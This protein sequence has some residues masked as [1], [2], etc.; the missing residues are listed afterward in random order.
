MI[1]FSGIQVLVGVDATKL[2]EHKILS[3]ESF[4]IV[5]FNF[6]HVGG[7]MRIE[8]NRALLRQFFISVKSILQKDGKVLMSLCDGQG[9]T[10]ADISR[11]QWNDS[12]QVTEMAAHGSFVLRAI[13]PFDS[14]LFKTYTVTGY[15]SLEKKF[16]TA[17]SLTHVFKLADRPDIANIA[18]KT[19]INLQ[20][21]NDKPIEWKNIIFEASID[22][23]VTDVSCNLS[24]YSKSYT[25][26]MTV[27]ID[28]EFTNAKFYESLYNNAGLIINN[29]EL[30]GCYKFPDSKETRTFRITYKSDRFPLYRKLVIDIH[31]NLIAG[32]VEKDLHVTVPR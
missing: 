5:V 3:F 2:E 15:R 11:R 30:I 27:S 10:P 16:N 9:G 23:N 13:E 20:Q 25:F 8:K 21:Y 18:P 28:S 4:D 24:L 6:P 7:K 14:S 31:E 12:W 19:K 29:V 17:G 1:F 22:V 26:D 32:I